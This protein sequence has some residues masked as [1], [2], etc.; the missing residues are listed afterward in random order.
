MRY[1]SEEQ[2]WQVLPASPPM[3]PPAPPPGL[4][5]SLCFESCDLTDQ[6]GSMDASLVNGATCTAGQGV[7]LDG[8]D[9]FVDL[10]D[11]PQGG[12]MSFAMWL[13]LDTLT[14]TNGG[15]RH[16]YLSDFYDGGQ[17]D[18]IRLY[19]I[20][21]GL[22]LVVW[23]EDKAPYCPAGN[24]GGG[25][26]CNCA[27]AIGWVAGEWLV[28]GGQGWCYE[29]KCYTGQP[30][31]ACEGTG[32]DFGGSLGD[33]TW[34]YD[35]RRDTECPVQATK[36]NAAYE[37]VSSYNGMNLI[38]ES[39]TAYW[40][41]VAATI[42]GSGLKVYLNG[43]LAGSMSTSQ[44]PERMQR[45]HHRLGRGAYGNNLAGKINS[46][47]VW[48]YGL[49]SD[50]VQQQFASGLCRSASSVSL[51]LSAT[52]TL[53]STYDPVLYQ[54]SNCVDGILDNFC[55]SRSNSDPSLT[56]DL[57][58][59][60]QIAYVTVYNRLQARNRLW[61]YQSPIAS[62]PQMRGPSAPMRHTRGPGMRAPRK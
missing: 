19:F 29:G 62:A 17:N 42:D 41:H 10:A 18:E 24:R 14:Q 39:D 48:E 2:D 49:T 57:G 54:A 15:N 30:Y 47:K 6:I 50:E 60:K 33:G 13:N 26:Y 12:A 31:A 55:H 16:Q 38:T 7:V 21:G 58:T 9:D 20:K 44:L 61:K 1:D 35:S 4:T 5:H 56:L 51:K 32:N 52:A 8:Q 25:G 43:T 23:P 53:S 46:F 27:G 3:S 36:A 28:N 22:R 34:C 11:A 37:S 59:A 40:M 45:V